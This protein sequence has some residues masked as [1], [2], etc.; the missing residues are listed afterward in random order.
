VDVYYWTNLLLIVIPNLDAI[1]TKRLLKF[2]QYED[3]ELQWKVK[4]AQIK[5]PKGDSADVETLNEGFLGLLPRGCMSMTASVSGQD[6]D[7]CKT[8]IRIYTSKCLHQYSNRNTESW[9]ST[10]KRKRKV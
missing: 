2:I 7:H 1:S 6:N 4:E 8:I 3:E 5:I 10:P 9:I